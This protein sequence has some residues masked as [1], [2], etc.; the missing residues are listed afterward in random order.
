[1]L[2]QTETELLNRQA[3]HYI[4][5]ITKPQIMKL[6]RQGVFQMELFAEK[7]CE[8]ECEGVR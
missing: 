6:L 5:A 1:M 2:K 7:V 3:F 4:T 8:G